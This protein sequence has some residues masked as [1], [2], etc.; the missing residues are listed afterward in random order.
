MSALWKMLKWLGA[1]CVLAGC[2]GLGL[3][4]SYLVKERLENAM[5]LKRSLLCLRGEISFGRTPLPEA[6]GRLSR[7][8][9]GVIAAFFTK[10]FL[11]LS[12]PG[13]PEN[14]L[15]EVWEEVARETFNG[16]ILTGK[17]LKEW[18][19]LGHT[20]GYLDSKMQIDTLNLYI[21]R[22]TQSLE[23]QREEKK[24]KVKLYNLLG[25][26]AGVFITIMII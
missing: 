14:G 20:I 2:S 23:I 7:K 4:Q 1:M 3:Y 16:K 11:Q 25:V 22:L 6:F 21:E 13:A 10:L 8:S 9:D 24:V 19:E 15:S 12:S 17:D 26:M 18:I 5:G